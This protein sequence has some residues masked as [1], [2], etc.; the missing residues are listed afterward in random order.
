M[1]RMQLR[2]IFRC[3]SRENHTVTITG[4]EKLEEVFFKRLIYDIMGEQA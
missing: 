3:T 4:Y 2:D 1:S